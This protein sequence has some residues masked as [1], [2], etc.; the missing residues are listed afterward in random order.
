MRLS[1]GWEA[2]ANT[3]SLVFGLDHFVQSPDQEHDKYTESEQ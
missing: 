1:K 2:S 3:S